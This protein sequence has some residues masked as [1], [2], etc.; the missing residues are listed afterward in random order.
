MC[1]RKVAISIYKLVLI[2][3]STYSEINKTELYYYFVILIPAAVNTIVGYIKKHITPGNTYEH[4]AQNLPPPGKED[5]YL[6]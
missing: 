3:A 6:R 5:V 4:A 1:Y 2:K